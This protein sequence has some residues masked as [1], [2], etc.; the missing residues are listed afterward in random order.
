[1]KTNVSAQAK[2]VFASFALT[3]LIAV[4]AW[5]ATQTVTLSVPDMTCPACP[6]TVKKALTQVDGVQKVEVSYKKRQAIVTFD[7]AKANVQVLTRATTNAGY[8]S[9]EVD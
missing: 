4:P 6:F 1:M 8:P 9:T 5:A 7:D 3:A 2:R